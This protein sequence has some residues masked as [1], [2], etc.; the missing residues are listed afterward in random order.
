MKMRFTHG[1]PS[2]IDEFR[3]FNFEI[4]RSDNTRVI[5][6]E[7]TV[8]TGNG[9][10][11][12]G[13][14][15]YAFNG[16]NVEDAAAYASPEDGV[17]HGYAYVLEVEASGFIN[18]LESDYLSGEDWA[19]IYDS[20][21]EGISEINGYDESKMYEKLSAAISLFEEHGDEWSEL[22]EAEEL[23]SEISDLSLGNFGA[24]DELISDYGDPSEWMDELIDQYRNLCD[25]TDLISMTI[26]KGCSL[27]ETIERDLYNHSDF[28]SV[29]KSMNLQLATTSNGTVVSL[30]NDLFVKEV[31]KRARDE[32][33]LVVARAGGECDFSIIF[34]PDAI[35]ISHT[36]DL[37]R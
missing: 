15:I 25:P 8:F 16:L 6:G 33:D 14:G 19:S 36:L 11:A 13:V 21:I 22:A 9:N 18:D 24:D 17:N 1:S 34:N 2:L 4:D 31:I 20:M 12:H 26:D 10:D 7:D 27:A 35:T 28:W 30:Y 32:D 37:N 5:F 3:L 23:I 29:L